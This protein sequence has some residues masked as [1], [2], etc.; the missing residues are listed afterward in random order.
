MSV[1]KD[2]RNHQFRDRRPSKELGHP[3]MKFGLANFRNTT[4]Q[5]ESSV[6]KDGSVSFKLIVGGKVV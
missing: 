2:A 6:R 3:Q 1:I 5:N 4:K